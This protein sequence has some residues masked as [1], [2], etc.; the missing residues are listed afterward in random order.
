MISINRKLK[1]NIEKI[2]FFLFTLTFLIHAIKYVYPSDS[3]KYNFH[4]RALKKNDLTKIF[5]ANT[6]SCLCRNEKIQI[7]EDKIRNSYEIKVNGTQVM[8]NYS[9][10][11]NEFESSIITCNPY[12]VLRQVL[13]IFDS[14]LLK[15]C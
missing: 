1:K 12:N 9:I 15:I 14:L 7:K 4:K 2:F 8:I 10:D 3:K 13:N 11:K 5:N 6:S